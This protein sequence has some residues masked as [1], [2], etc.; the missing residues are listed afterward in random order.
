MIA[1]KITLLI[2]FVFNQYVIAQSGLWEK[3]KEEDQVFS[4]FTLDYEYREPGLSFD[5]DQGIKISRSKIT[6]SQNA[7]ALKMV[8]SFSQEPTYKNPGY[9][10]Y[11][12]YDY[13][14]DGDLI[15]WRT[16]AKHAISNPKENLSVLE[17][18]SCNI[19]EIRKV[20]K[21]PPR[22]RKT[23]FDLGSIDNIYEWS[24]VLMGIG[25]GFSRFIE[26]TEL[27]EELPE[28]MIEIAAKGNYGEGM[29]GTWKMSIDRSNGYIVRKAEFFPDG[30]SQPYLLVETEGTMQ[31]E[32]FSVAAKGRLSFS[33]PSDYKFVIE[34]T[35]R[36]GLL[37]F[38]QAFYDQTA[39]NVKMDYPKMTVMDLRK[40]K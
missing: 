31:G 38:D 32:G 33:F 13:N 24:H 29:T 18:Q 17:L 19:S 26:T 14:P 16:L 30:K 5:P 36:S 8:N 3:L 25:R 2:L 39:A 7:T 10:D 11:R 35:P 28:G 9:R 37:S 12:E 27:V 1:K 6:V 23:H 15:I 40:G 21:L 4:E 20:T 22:Y 34:V